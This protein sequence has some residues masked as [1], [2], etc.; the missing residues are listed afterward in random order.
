[1]RRAPRAALRAAMATADDLDALLGAEAH[2]TWQLAD[3]L[4]SPSL[5]VRA[6][7]P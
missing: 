3:V 5:M 6:S 7:V 1:L 2:A 4:W